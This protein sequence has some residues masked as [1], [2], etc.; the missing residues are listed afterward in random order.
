M[1]LATTTAQEFGDVPGS[2]ARQ[3]AVSTGRRGRAVA[4]TLQ[5]ACALLLAAWLCRAGIAA[6]LPR[7]ARDPATCSGPRDAAT[8]GVP[9]GRTLY[10]QRPAHRDTL[11]RRLPPLRGASG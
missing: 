4:R 10:P 6:S 5:S 9:Q 11:P 7:N 2:P 8:D 3:C 1:L